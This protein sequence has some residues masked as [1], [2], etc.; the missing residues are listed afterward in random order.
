[1]LKQVSPNAQRLFKLPRSSWKDYDASLISKGGGIFERSAKS[2]ALSK[3]AQAA[4]GI[5]KA[6]I[7]PDD[8]IR[9]I[10][11]SPVDLLW[12]GGIGTYVKAEDE[13]NEQ[14]GDR[15]NNAVRVNGKELRC[16][17]VGE[18][19]NLGLTQKGRIEYA[20]SGGRIN[21]DAIDNSGGVDCSDH[22][23]NIK[24]AFAHE[25]AS[26]K[27]T[28]AKR[29][30]LLTS[31]TGEVARLVL[32]DNFLQTQAITIVQQQG[33]LLVEAQQRLMHRLEQEGL[34]D[35]V[36]E[37]LPSDK[38]L[39][40]LKA[41]K[42]GLT[43]P[44]L[45]VLLAYS[46]MSLYKELLDSSLPD[47][48]Y[49]TSDLMRYFP[50]AMQEHFADA[51][52]HHA[53]KREIIATVMTNSLIN[54]AGITF[55]SAM[56]EDFGASARDV[57]AAYALVRDVFGLRVLWKEIEE[58]A[59]TIPVA[60]LGQIYAA[61]GQF[62][63]RTAGWFLRHMKLPLDIDAVSRELVPDVASLEKNKAS[64]H[65]KLTQSVAEETIE[66]LMAQSVPK[67]LAEKV[68]GLELMASAPDIIA[69]AHKNNISAV[70]VGRA[71]FELGM[72]LGLG[73]LRGSAADIAVASYWERQA[74]QALVAEL[75][76]EERRLTDAAITHKGGVSKWLAD[77][78]GAIAKLSHFIEDLKAGGP[79]DLPKLTVALKHIRALGSR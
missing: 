27:L 74:I 50:K 14:V 64:L 45:A 75:S 23:V 8:L 24:I 6:N 70:D 72:A 51:I 18:G 40:D 37:F 76:D 15:A 2:I 4:L 55:A 17:V 66:R 73:W 7:A 78:E 19:G 29:N 58:N 48:P 36:I 38:Q 56:Q 9:A 30:K 12:N 60:T 22:E 5:S 69:L 10:L 25:I 47:E 54:R 34:L 32:K 49:F 31:M 16:K 65:S 52:N 62:M 11:L 20:R 77:H 46:K 59:G 67:S 43:R 42:K 3:E 63:E 1:M 41:A 35:R 53:L 79:A 39:A 44:E 26:G 21:T 68:V 71:Y 57:S 28:T 13:S 33:G 61:I